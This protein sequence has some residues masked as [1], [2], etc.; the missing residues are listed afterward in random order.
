MR[1][2]VV[3]A[4]LALGV[5]TVAPM[6][7]AASD[8]P[9]IAL[10][11]KVMRRNGDFDTARSWLPH[12][13]AVMANSFAAGAQQAD[14]TV[15]QKALDKAV[16]RQAKKYTP[17]FVNADAQA[18]AKVYSTDEMNQILAWY[19]KSAKR[20]GK[21]PQFIADKAQA[22]AEQRAANYAALRPK[23][24]SDVFAAYCTGK[25]PCDDKVRGA[26]TAYGHL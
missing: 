6:A 21:P 17:Q 25:T 11:K 23:L 18:Y 5:M 3:A 12:E 20:R 7:T 22:L 19:K 14:L 2:L 4:A 10:A 9:A 13:A 26:I 16:N 1:G 8:P 24:R 15:N